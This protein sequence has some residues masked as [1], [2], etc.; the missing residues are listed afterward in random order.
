[1]RTAPR[2]PL[3]FL[4][5]ATKVPDMLSSGFTLAATSNFELSN[6]SAR[7]KCAGE[8]PFCESFRFVTLGK[9]AIAIVAEGSAF[10]PYEVDSNL[11]QPAEC[12]FVRSLG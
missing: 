6:F 3:N 12:F 7:L 5:S 11:S 10:F 9:L 8:T 1:M 4:C 2:R